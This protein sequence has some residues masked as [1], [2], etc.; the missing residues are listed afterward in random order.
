MPPFLRWPL[1]AL[2]LLF[3]MPVQAL[4]VYDVIQLSQKNYSDQDI[5]ALIQ[6]T[7]S[8][9]KLQAE[10]VV[11][12][13]EMGLGEP[14]IQAML[15]AAPVEAKNHPAASVID[16]Q[17]H[18]EPL[19][20]VAQKTIAGGRFDFEAFQEAES[21]SHHHNAVIL[22]GV[23]LLV[24]RATGEFTSVAARADAVVKRLEQAVSMG[25]G[26]FRATAAGGNH[27]VMFY[28]RSADKPVSILQV[29]HR[30][31]HAYQKRSGRKVTPVLLA[32]YWSDLLSDYWSITINKTAPNR[33]ADVHDGEVLTA[34]HQQWQ[35]SRETTS[36]QLADAAQLLP[37]RQQQH[38]LRLASTVPHDF[39]I[40]RTHLVKPP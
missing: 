28:A 40:N 22:A 4:S 25:A 32:A 35:T 10:D 26:T 17:T 29:S 31:A 8:A 9:F 36:A 37:R 14:L 21:G 7:N 19:V 38:L 34:L 33:L 30:E 1:V 27:A 5:Q 12:L 13:K 16:E 20:P 11:Q 2:A 3:M 18:S 23:Q 6:A 15:K 24:L 39:L